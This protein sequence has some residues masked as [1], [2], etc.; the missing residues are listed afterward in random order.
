MVTFIR[1]TVDT[2]WLLLCEFGN[3]L[4]SPQN[5]ILD[6]TLVGELYSWMPKGIG[7][8][9]WSWDPWA[10]WD[11]FRASPKVYIIK[12]ILN[13][14][15]LFHC[16]NIC[17]DGPKALRDKATGWCFSISQG[18]GTK[19]YLVVIVFFT[20]IYT[21]RKKVSVTYKKVF[22]EAV[23]KLTNFIKS[24]SLSTCLF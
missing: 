14:T 1:T 11:P 5:K 13:V 20:T 3:F 9:V 7:S 6:K 17:S 2:V 8:Q 15:C 12:I 4:C 18:S 22:D 23:V 16:I 24:P 19:L 21:W 10:S